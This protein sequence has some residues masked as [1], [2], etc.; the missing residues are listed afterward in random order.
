MWGETPKAT[1][2]RRILPGSRDRLA[3]QRR[4]RAGSKNGAS[5][6]VVTI[7]HRSRSVNWRTTPAQGDEEPRVALAGTE[8]GRPTL[9]PFV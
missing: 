5:S 2:G 9:A 4:P 6:D 7:A 3:R 1:A 8:P